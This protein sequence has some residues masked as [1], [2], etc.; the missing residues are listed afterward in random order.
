[1]D[2]AINK[3]DTCPELPKPRSFWQRIGD[4]LAA[5]IGT[6]RAATPPEKSVAFTIAVIS[7]GAKLAKADGAV[8]RSEVAAFRRLFIIPRAEEKNAGRVFDL[9]RQDVAGFD[10]WAQRIAAMDYARVRADPALM[11][12][13]REDG[14]R[15]FG[16]NCAACHGERGEGGLGVGAPSLADGQWIYGGD[17]ASIRATLMN[18]RAGVMP[19]W[20]GRLSEAD[21]RAVAAWVHS[22]G[23][24]E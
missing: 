11:A 2:A 10:A 5:I 21:I 24:G 1:M 7:L 19:S 13:V 8:A 17:P 3:P 22:R 20:Q 18:G 9:A 4:R 6:R 23:G 16:D 12:H 15:L 14:H